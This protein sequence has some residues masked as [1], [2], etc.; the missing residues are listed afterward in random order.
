LTD[1]NFANN[2]ADRSGAGMFNELSNPT[3]TDC[4]FTNNIADQSGGGMYNNDDSN[5]IVT[6]C[7]FSD[8]TATNVAGG[9]CNRL[10]NPTVTDCTF[11]GNSSTNNGGGI[12]NYHNN[13]ALIRCTFT[14]NTTTVDGGGVYNNGGSSTITDCLFSSNSADYGGGMY[15]IYSASPTVTN[16]VFLNNTATGLS[17][18]AE[19]GGGMLNHISATPTLINCVF[20]GNNEYGICNLLG[21]L[22]QATVIN[23]ILWGDEPN[24][25]FNNSASNTNVTYSDVQ[26]GWGDPNDPNNTNIDA[27][28]CFVDG[29]NPDPNLWNLRLKPG[30]PCIDAGDTTAVP[31]GTWA[32]IGGNPRVLDDP[33]ISDTGV[34]LSSLTVDMGAYEFDCMAIAGDNNCDGVV[35]FKDIAILCNNWLAGTEPEL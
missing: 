23:C 13:M 3:V 34:S 35:D 9:M 5:S 16:C 10:S 28:P 6:N 33:Q 25:I 27:D 29:N 21:G 20:R 11:T 24:E 31:G 8:N 14:G 17:A 12:Y 2:I 26:G 19:G 22:S 32:D 7:T 4:N 15:N 18:G 30:S 1:C